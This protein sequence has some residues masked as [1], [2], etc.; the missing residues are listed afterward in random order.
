MQPFANPFG[1]TST[2]NVQHSQPNQPPSFT[3]G[4]NKNKPANNGGGQQDSL[5]S[6]EIVKAKRRY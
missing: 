5:F 6:R 2:T 1:G 4:G 3:L